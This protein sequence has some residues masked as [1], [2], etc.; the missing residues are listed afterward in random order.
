MNFSYE[1][2]LKK[3]NLLLEEN[4]DLKR[5]IT[6]LTGQSKVTKQNIEKNNKDEEFVLVNKFSSPQGKIKLYRPL[7][8]GR[9]DF[10]ARRWYSKNSDKSGYQPV[11]ENEWDMALC[12]KKKYKCS[13]CPN[14][15]LAALTDQVIYEYLS[16]KD[17]YGRDVV[18]IYPM[19]ND[20]T[21]YFLCA[22]FDE[23]NFKKDV[24][25]FRK[26][27]EENNI[28]VSVEISRSGNGAHAWIFFS[29]PVSAATARKLGRGILTK[30]MEKISIS[31]SS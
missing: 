31:F 20:A 21:C 2:L 8:R 10:F 4:R 27:C 29:E 22:D 30:A 1:E 13:A 25:V 18:G 19:L 9:E 7:F 24:S 5:E 17:L 3:Y 12:D 15:K 26:I 6:F 16:G 28:P 23:E 14:R 11:C